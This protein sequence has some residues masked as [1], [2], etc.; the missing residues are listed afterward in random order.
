MAVGI[1]DNEDLTSLRVDART[2]ERLLDAQR[3]CTFAFTTEEGWPAG[4]VMSYLY[5]DGTFW[6]TAAS[7]RAHVRAARRDP[8]VTLVVSNAGTD[9]AG[10]RMLAVRGRVTVRTDE[11]TKRWF[12]PAFA[13]HHA[14]NDPDAFEQLLDSPNRVVLE[15]R[16]VRIAVSHDSTK[17]P[18]DGRGGGAGTRSTRK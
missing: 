16:P 9:L 6:L 8:R 17:M 14:P 10:R 7:G 15:V 1:D 13:H 18:G 3:E 11:E 12:Y 5:R 4:V 2:Q